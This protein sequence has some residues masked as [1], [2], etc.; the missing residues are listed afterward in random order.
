MIQIEK[1]YVVKRTKVKDELYSTIDA[2]SLVFMA[3]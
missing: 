1:Y 3:N 2:A